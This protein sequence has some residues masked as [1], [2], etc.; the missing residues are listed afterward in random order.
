MDLSQL[1]RQRQQAAH[2]RRRI[3]YNDDG[4]SIVYNLAG[5]PVSA[6]ALLDDRLGGLVGTQVD[7]IAYC[8]WCSSFGLVTHRT[9][10]AEPFVATSGPF[11]ANQTRAYH[12][13]GLDP[14]RITADFCRTHDIELLWSLRMNDIHDADPRWVELHSGFKRAHPELLFGRPDAP[15]AFGE[16]SGLD[17]AAPAVRA[18]AL[19]QLEEACRR[20]A[21]DGVELDFL[22]HPPHFRCGTRGDDCT[23][24]ERDL[25][26]DLL[27]RA[28]HM[29]EAVGLERGRPLLVGVRVPA[30]VDCCAALGLDVERWLV[31]DL[32]DL[33]VPGEWELSPWSAWA[34]L[35][36]CHGVP[37]Y[38][39]LSWTG[40]KKRQGPPA[41]QQGLPYRHFRSRAMNVWHSGADGVYVFNLFDPGHPAWHELGEPAT[42]ARLDKDYY[43]DGYWRA[44]TGHDLR[45]PER[46]LQQGTTLCPDAPAIL[47][48]GGSCEVTLTVGE[49]LPSFGVEVLVSVSTDPTDPGTVAVTVNDQPAAVGAPHEGWA[50]GAVSPS[51]V[52]HGANIVRV[53]HA[54]T[55]HGDIT[56]RDVH[57]QVARQDR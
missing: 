40:S 34:A 19:A 30:S 45:S 8:S 51:W 10:V 7:S 39:C 47:V 16:W 23:R 53:T 31:D 21:I 20:Y 42:L 35:G 33:L 25:M 2:R 11:A 55:T 41:A 13:A 4:N 12:E 26:T 6:A 48:P 1:R 49:A 17:Y 36:Q 46:F 22:R 50:T 29:T 28:R 43:P 9:D 52:R 54:G 24:I 3:M 18:H 37:V 32:V 56:L 14:L 44:L 57:L 27:R 38:P 5:K 15:P